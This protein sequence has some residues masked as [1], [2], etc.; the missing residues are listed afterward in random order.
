MPAWMASLLTNP[1]IVAA[2]V[3]AS[4]SLL[5][6]FFTPIRNRT[7]ER[8][9]SELADISASRSAR[10]DYEYEARKRL[11]QEIEPLLFQ[12][13]EAAEEAFYRVKSLART[14]RKGKLHWLARKRYY[15]RSTVHKLLLPA[16]LLRIVQRQMTFVDLRVDDTIQVKYYLMKLYAYSFTDD[17]DIAALIK[18]EPPFEYE[19]DDATAEKI[20]SDPAGHIRQGLYVGTVENATDAMIKESDLGGRKNLRPVTFGEFWHAIAIG[21]S[22]PTYLTD[23]VD[24]YCNFDDRT[25]PVLAH[26]LHAQGCIAKLILAAFE[27]SLQG[28]SLHHA[29][30]AFLS[31]AEFQKDFEW[32]EGKR[33]DAHLVLAYIE[34]S[35]RKISGRE[36]QAVICGGSSRSPEKQAA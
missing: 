8:L 23:V 32:S 17:F 4:A 29:L 25:N 27:P 34:T 5:V 19:P 28:R 26:M 16:V 30:T 36:L 2:L 1:A 11:Y 12:L 13:H 6:M 9:K 22:T 15:L 3:G 33:P 20:E 14:A 21:R 7:L 10:R 35:F 31:S 24:L 18:Q